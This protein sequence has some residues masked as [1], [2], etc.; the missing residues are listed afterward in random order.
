M[1]PLRLT[2]SA[3][4]LATLT[5]CGG[6]DLYVRDGPQ[7]VHPSPSALAS[8]ARHSAPQVQSVHHIVII[9]TTTPCGHTRHCAHHKKYHGGNDGSRPIV[10]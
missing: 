4:A 5:A 7:A 9:N 2:A 6:G 3:L 1:T 10:D 8:G